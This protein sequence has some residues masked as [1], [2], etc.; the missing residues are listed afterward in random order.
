VRGHA[1]A[2]FAIGMLTR[3]PLLNSSDINAAVAFGKLYEDVQDCVTWI[4][5]EKQPETPC[6]LPLGFFFAQYRG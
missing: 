1:K 6:P 3:A 2:F 5:V 4:L